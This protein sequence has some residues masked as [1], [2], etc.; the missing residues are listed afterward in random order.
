MTTVV[1]TGAGGG[2]GRGIALAC[3]TDGMFVVV[4]SRHDDGAETVAMI[5]AN[6]GRGL[7]VRCDVTVRADV[8]RAVAAVEQL[9]AFVHNAASRRSSS[10]CISSARSPPRPAPRGPSES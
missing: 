5:E 8:E 2:L 6:G 9:G 3:A 7:W 1:V 10:R 4:A